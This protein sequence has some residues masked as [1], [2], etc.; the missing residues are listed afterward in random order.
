MVQTAV[1]K[2]LSPSPED[3]NIVKLVASYS[4]VVG[5]LEIQDNSKELQLITQ[6]GQ[7][8]TGSNT[9]CKHLAKSGCK[10]SELLGSNSEDE[11]LVRSSCNFSQFSESIIWQQINVDR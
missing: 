4:G 1:F 3:S 11:A 7:T 2:L 8:L 6:T 5:N 9:I 10:A